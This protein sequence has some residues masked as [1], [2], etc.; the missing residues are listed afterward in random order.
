M[1]NRQAG[2]VDHWSVVRSLPLTL[3]TQHAH[4]A[5]QSDVILS[6]SLFTSKVYAR[7]FPSLA[8][9]P[10]KVVYP[11]IDVSQY[12][13]NVKTESDEGVDLVAW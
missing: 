4:Q 12:Q 8:K 6:N 1:A 2:G 5:G 3:G 10:P 13:S 11:C 7:A 9:R